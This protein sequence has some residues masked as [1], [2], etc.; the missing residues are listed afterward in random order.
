MPMPIINHAI[1]DRFWGRVDHASDGCWNWT[2]TK[3]GQGYGVMDFPTPDGFKQIRAHR[4]A[5]RLS[6]GY[7][8]DKVVIRHRCDNPSC[9][10]H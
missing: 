10:G 1:Q 4:V 8:H 6:K 5:Y 7:V 2:L 9:C 3:N